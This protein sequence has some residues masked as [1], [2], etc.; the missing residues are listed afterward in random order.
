MYDYLWFVNERE[1]RVEVRITYGG[2]PV[3][4]THHVHINLSEEAA[5]EEAESW[6]REQVRKL[7][8]APKYEQALH[9]SSE[10][11][12]EARQRDQER[13][14]VRSDREYLWQLLDDISSMDDLCK[15]N[16]AAY[17]KNVRRIAEKRHNVAFSEDGYTL[18]WVRDNK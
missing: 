6:A 18:V 11:Q 4:N 10:K 12:D 5:V 16:D 15:G 14:A 17:R 13:F 3:G 8:A 2:L 9:Y 1:R 7:G